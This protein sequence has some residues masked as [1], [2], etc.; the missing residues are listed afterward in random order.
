MA[1]RIDN[2]TR[3]QLIGLFRE[4]VCEVMEV[5]PFLHQRQVWAASDG[6]E[7]TGEEDPNGL[8][9]RLESAAVSSVLDSVDDLKAELGSS[10]TWAHSRLERA[11]ELLSGPLAL[12]RS[13]ER[14]S[15]LLASSMTSVPQSSPTSVSSSSPKEE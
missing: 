4:R 5:A 10:P 7:L 12:L 9:V 14:E 15:H 3:D 8:T 2:G 6:L 13:L 11:M 1:P